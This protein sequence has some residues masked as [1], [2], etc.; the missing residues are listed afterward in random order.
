MCACA[1]VRVRVCAC[2]C[3]FPC[4]TF[5]LPQCTVRVLP[6]RIGTKGAALLCLAGLDLPLQSA[7][8]SHTLQILYHKQSAELEEEEEEEGGG[9]GELIPDT[10]QVEP[11]EL[12]TC[13]PF[14]ISYVDVLLNASIS[15]QLLHTTCEKRDQYKNTPRAETMDSYCLLATIILIQTLKWDQT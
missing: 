14:I 5:S 11:I 1:C 10:H 13:F 3:A 15:Q 6:R 9:G 4:A 8:H 7:A 12:T 2:T